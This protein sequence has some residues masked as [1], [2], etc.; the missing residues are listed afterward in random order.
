M[1]VGEAAFHNAKFLWPF[2]LVLRVWTGQVDD[3]I[4]YIVPVW[5][6]NVIKTSSEFKCGETAPIVH[7]TDQ[8]ILRQ[9]GQSSKSHAPIEYLNWW[10]CIVTDK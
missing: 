3:T 4:A 10:Y 7:V 5:A 9:K 1:A 2:V 8:P 6:H